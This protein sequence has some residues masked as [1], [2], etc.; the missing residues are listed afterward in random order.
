M[1]RLLAIFRERLIAI[2]AIDFFGSAGRDRV[3]ALLEQLMA[4]GRVPGG[5]RQPRHRDTG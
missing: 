1:R 2:D 5:Q 3:I 4:D